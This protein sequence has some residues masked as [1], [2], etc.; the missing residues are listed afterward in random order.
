MKT[1]HVALVAPNVVTRDG[2]G[3][4]MVELCRALV[5][6]GHR[7]TVLA[8]RCDDDV[9]GVVDFRPV[10]RPPGPQLVDDLYL[11]A[12]ATRALRHLE[13]DVAVVMGPCALTRRPCVYNAQFSHHGW[14]ATWA[15]GRPALYHRIHVRLLEWLTRVV[16]RRCD[17]V[18]A[19]T[20]AV[21]VDVTAGTATPCSI[22]PDGVDAAEFPVVT[23]HRRAEARESLGLSADD[24]VIAFLGDYHTPRKGLDPLLRA[25]AAGP[26]DERLVV[27]SRGNSRALDRRS[28]ALGVADRV[29]VAGFAHPGTV[30]AAADVV[31]VPSIYEP[32]SLVAFEAAASGVPLVLSLRAGAAELLAGCAHEVVDPSDPGQLRAA[33]DRVWADPAGSRELTERARRVAETMAWP[34]LMERAARVIESVAAGASARTGSARTGNN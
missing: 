31:A 28:E 18:I 9:R 27:A 1:L 20:D 12:A 26:G 19:S 21:G 8:H 24:R 6:A 5:G 32:F 7:V 34:G 30:I 16:V 13:H 4:V 33:L 17:R 29:T 11:L 2:Q 15:H 10:R 25:V 3:R 14:R 23:E 22:V